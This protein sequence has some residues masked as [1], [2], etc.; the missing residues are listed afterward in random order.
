VQKIIQT[1][2]RDIVDASQKFSEVSMI[3]LYGIGA[4]NRGRG[5]RAPLGIF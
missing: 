2:K 3:N 1:Y 4:G 5:A